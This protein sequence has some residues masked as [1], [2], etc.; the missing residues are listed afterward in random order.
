MKGRTWGSI[1][2]VH[3]RESSKARGSGSEKGDC[4]S[5]GIGERAWVLKLLRED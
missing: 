1:K 5:A 3:A 4:Q 2:I